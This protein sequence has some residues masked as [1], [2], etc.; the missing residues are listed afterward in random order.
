MVNQKQR[1]IYIRWCTD[2]KAVFIMERE[3]IIRLILNGIVELSFSS[4]ETAAGCLHSS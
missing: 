2:M 3:E 4:T 1:N